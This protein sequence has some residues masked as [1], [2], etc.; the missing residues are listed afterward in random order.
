MS[1]QLESIDV[2]QLKAFALDLGDSEVSVPVP[3]PSGPACMQAILTPC[4]LKARPDRHPGRVGAASD[5]PSESYNP[6]RSHLK[7]THVTKIAIRDPNGPK[8]TPPSTRDGMRISPQRHLPSTIPESTKHN[9]QQYSTVSQGDTQPA[10]QWVYDYFTSK[11]E[12]DELSNTQL[13]IRR[14]SQ[15]E[16]E[17]GDDS[18]HIDLLGGFEQPSIISTAG[19]D[20]FVGFD[21]D[22]V[23]PLSQDIHA[24]IFPESKR[25]Q[26]PKTPASQGTKR[27]RWSQRPSDDMQTPSLPENP[28]ADRVNDQEM[29]RPSQLFNATQAVTSPINAIFELGSDRPSPDLH[30]NQ[31]PPAT[32]TQSS[33]VIPPRSNMTRAVTEPQTTYVSM[34]ESQEARAHRLQ[35]LEGTLLD[36]LSDDDFNTV[37]IQLRKRLNRKRINEA[38]R[39]QFAGVTARSQPLSSGHIR[40][41]RLGRSIDQTHSSP[42]QNGRQAS[43]AVLISD[44]T[45]PE[46]VQGNGTEEETEREDATEEKTMDETGELGEENKENVEVPMTVSRLHQTGSLPTVSQH[47]PS[48]HPPQRSARVSRAYQATL[49]TSS[50][51]L[52]RSPERI[53][54]SQSGS[55]AYAVVD[56][57]SSQQP[58]TNRRQKGTQR[59]HNGPPSS[60]DSRVMV[61][62]SQL[63]QILNSSAGL[64]KV[65]QEQVSSKETWHP[66]A[67]LHHAKPDHTETI[68][69]TV[70]THK[71]NKSSGT[72]GTAM[73]NQSRPE[74]KDHQ[75]D[76]FEQGAK[77]CASI[78]D[79]DRTENVNR[80]S[81][82]L[83]SEPSTS[84]PPLRSTTKSAPKADSDQIVGGPSS[85]STLFE[86]AREQI[87][88][89]P[90]KSRVQSLQHTSIG[91]TSSPAK[92]QSQPIRTMQQITGDPS[93]PDPF[94][95]ID[96]GS[97]LSK[98]EIEDQMLIKGP[99]P[100]LPT[101]EIR[102]IRNGS[103]HSIISQRQPSGET[104]PR[105]P[106]W[107]YS[108]L[109]SQ[110]EQA[111]SDTEVE[112]TI[113]S[114]QE[115]VT[116]MESSKAVN[117]PYPVALAP[118]PAPLNFGSAFQHGTP[119]LSLKVASTGR[120]DL[121]ERRS[122]A[123]SYLKNTSVT[124]ESM[125]P[126]AVV[127]PNRVF[128]HFNGSN[129][130]FYP[131]TCTG[132]TLGNEP[133]FHVTFD[134]GSEDIISGF[135]IKRL[136]LR[137]G[138]MCKVDREGF[139][140]R[141]L[142]V[143]NLHYPYQPT[144]PDLPSRKGPQSAKSISTG[145]ETD[146]FGHTHVTVIPK[147]R[148]STGG[149]ASGNEEFVV[150]LSQVYLTHTLW[151]SI[152]DRDYSFVSDKQPAMTELQTPSE[153]PST[154]SSPSSRVRR[155]RQS[156]LLPSRL[157]KVVV[158]RKDGLF[159]NMVFTLTNIANPEHLKR[160][161]SLIEAN[162]GRI[163]ESGFDELFH[164]PDLSRTSSP[165]KSKADSFQLATRAKRTGF[166]C[167]I[168]DGHCR[169]AKYIQALA[170]GIPCLAT[171]WIRDCVTRG[172]LLP[173]SPYLLPAG[174][175]TF[176]NG[177]IR[178]RVL[179][180]LPN[181][182]HATLSDIISQRPQMLADTSILLI[183]QKH[184][185]QTMK[186]HSFL[187]HALGATRVARATSAEGAGRAV[188]EALGKGERWD[189]VYTHDREKET[190]KSIFGRAGSKKRKQALEGEVGRTRVVGNELV[191]QSLILGQLAEM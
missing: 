44:N 72:P 61:P 91:K 190:E 69:E 188:A 159:D 154:P 140:S 42:L 2:S 81:T 70:F 184:E 168:A 128:A 85:A 134:D 84:I 6:R 48:H 129:L 152:K 147:R 57:Q 130:A 3:R 149:E 180:P 86:T 108:P 169:R 13:T 22:D 102:R 185:E 137:P 161:K 52:S 64:S 144:D 51:I 124:I 100:R 37:D 62:Q 176:L 47:T 17:Y 74:I 178:S 7:N 40:H 164:V 177:A 120:A 183:M 56:S 122:S 97:I 158:G 160:T 29:L 113:A 11:N 46:E 80:L 54:M 131:A 14:N 39:T 34:K 135:E 95:D 116:T 79:L 126:P 60:L 73:N 170:L 118:D 92:S 172:I 157:D 119:R 182:M 121:A 127:A 28:F 138:E 78:A 146:I 21:E 63:S 143:V 30:S 125:K 49:A 77:G 67:Q 186:H 66:Q 99:S 23:D 83:P 167:L 10:S 165:S 8:A 59:Q 90:S 93:P 115:K 41:R 105:P 26:L 16:A 150:P 76:E 1:T 4:S 82:P 96:V 142:I 139:R 58:R 148:G 114:I 162:A 25:F 107:A 88:N 141:N 65:E 153:R 104:P 111:T 106:S 31:R 24:E 18:G 35:A 132:S 112:P 45:P 189:W 75:P 187:T 136:E 123:D 71:T 179:D 43:E 94:G 32:N 38:A 133:R 33:P 163:L 181:P 175:S 98:N 174:E 55:Q 20:V 166:T 68:A 191:I 171:R 27:K 36:E 110:Q 89:T 50:P 156:A 109:T 15:N 117:Q 101:P 87:A 5:A 151:A 12:A 9:M 19:E 103:S 53:T 173:L 145:H 155:A